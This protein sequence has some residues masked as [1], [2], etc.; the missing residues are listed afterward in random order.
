MVQISSLFLGLKA[1]FCIEKNNTHRKNIR[2]LKRILIGTLV[3][4]LAG[5]LEKREDFLMLPSEVCMNVLNILYRCVVSHNAASCE[6][7]CRLQ[8]GSVG[9]VRLIICIA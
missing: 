8:Y 5:C 2:R 3:L 7:S 1:D 9:A 4:V 6:V